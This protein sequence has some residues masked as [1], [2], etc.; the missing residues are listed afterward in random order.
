MR[1]TDK[2]KPFVDDSVRLR[3]RIAEL[4]AIED[5]CKLAQEKLRE[6]EERY[7]VLFETSPDL[8]AHI[9]RDGR[10]LAANP[11][12]A[13]HFN[14]P[15]KELI[16][17][18]LSDVMPEKATEHR[19]KFIRRAI[20][21]GETQYFE[22]EREGRHLH[23]RVVPIKIPGQKLTAKMVSQ[24]ITKRKEAEKKLRESE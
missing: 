17:K 21:E 14:T 7:R 18:K 13:E 22:A 16:G 9:D 2:I 10:F 1:N 24:D 8:I 15:L 12:S 11:A 4:E 20:D 5:E 19:L 23:T 3:Q 6:S